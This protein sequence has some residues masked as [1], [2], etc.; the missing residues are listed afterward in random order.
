M[1][2]SVVV[3]WL[4][5]CA[6][7]VVV[8]EEENVDVVVGTVIVATLVVVLI[9]VL[10]SVTVVL[11]VGCGAAWVGGGGACAVDLDGRDFCPQFAMQIS[12]VHVLESEEH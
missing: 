10:F 4:V 9:Y 8:S 2:C 11:D 3:E 6:G 12:D 5:V 7:V 1:A